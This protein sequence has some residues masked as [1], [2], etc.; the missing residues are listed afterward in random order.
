VHDHCRV[1]LCKFGLY[2]LSER[3]AHRAATIPLPATQP[4]TSASHLVESTPASPFP[5]LPSAGHPEPPTHPR[6]A[7][8]DFRDGVAPADR[9]RGDHVG[10]ERFTA[11]EEAGV[12]DGGA[13]PRSAIRQ[14]LDAGAAAH[15][16]SLGGTGV[17]TRGHGS[18]QGWLSTTWERKR[19]SSVAQRTG[20]PLCAQWTET[21][22]HY[23]VLRSRFG[24]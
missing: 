3:A 20:T 21:G 13:A 22:K 1:A 2:G 4:R 17:A 5:D 6:D 14:L 15:Y 18:L 11:I 24:Q 19:K 12:A 7:P 16:Y 23:G 8:C 10:L 9:E